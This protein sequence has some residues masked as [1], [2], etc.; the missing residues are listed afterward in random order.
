M[1]DIKVKRNFAVNFSVRSLKNGK[2]NDRK[3]FQISCRTKGG[4]KRKR[5]ISE[6]LMALKNILYVPVDHIVCDVAV[7]RMPESRGKAR[8]EEGPPPVSESRTD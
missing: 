2:T 7:R 3:K 1:N 5:K 8:E 6:L 4:N